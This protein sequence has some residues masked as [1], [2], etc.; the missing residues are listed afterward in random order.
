MRISDSKHKVR[1]K[2]ECKKFTS[3]PTILLFSPICLLCYIF[4][5]P[6]SFVCSLFWWCYSPAFILIWS[7]SGG[8]L[9]LL[10][11][12][13][14]AVLCSQGNLCH[15]ACHLTL[16][17]SRVSDRWRSSWW[18]DQTFRNG[19]APFPAFF[20]PLHHTGGKREKTRRN[21]GLTWICTSK[22]MH[23]YRRLLSLPK[24]L[25]NNSCNF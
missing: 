21:E 14:G 11:D 6:S 1:R 10:P 16:T 20:V 13:P 19:R 17:D 15:L 22:N 9:F 8:L 23:N 12:T 7:S 24:P 25:H 2:R 5:R 4:L 3:F 18:P